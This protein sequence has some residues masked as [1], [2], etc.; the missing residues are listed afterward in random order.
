MVEDNPIVR[1]E[2]AA[3]LSDAG[4]DVIAMDN[5]DSA[6]SYVFE[7]SESIGAI[8]ADVQMPGDTDGLDLAQYIASNWPHIT[9]LLT[10]GQVR[11]SCDLPGNIKFFLK[12]WQPADILGTLQQT[13][14]TA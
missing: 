10:S 14:G 3:M 5:G 6:L 13:V 4:L 7:Q 1:S 9:I 2:A 8:F 11:P 12:P